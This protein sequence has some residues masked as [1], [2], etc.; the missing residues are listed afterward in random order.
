MNSRKILHSRTTSV[1]AGSALLVTLGGVSG[2]FAAAQ[3]TSQDIKNGEV[4]KVDVGSEAVGASEVLNKSLGTNDLSD[5]AIAAM[6]GQKGDPGG[7]G[8]YTGPEWSVIDRNVLGGGDASLRSGPTVKAFGQDVSPPAGVGSLG[9]RT[10][11]TGDKAAFGD[12]VDFAG[13]KLADVTAVKFSVFT[14]GENGAGNLPNL[15]VEVNP[16]LKKPDGS[17]ITYSTLNFVPASAKANEW[18]EVD[19]STDKRWYFTGTAGAA[20]GCTAA[21]MCSLDEVHTKAPEATIQTVAFSKGSGDAAFSG[22]VDKLVWGDT[23]Y[24]FEPF[25]VRGD[26]LTQR[27]CIREGRARTPGPPLVVRPSSSA[28]F[29][30]ARV[31][32]AETAAVVRAAGH[33]S[34]VVGWLPSAEEGLPS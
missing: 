12:Q 26:Q 29:V 11:G 31:R 28:P 1:I 22:A 5:A 9:I 34:P 3:I 14:T 30:R 17:D 33:P 19:G 25:G 20:S 24:D 7:P 10:G 4:K 8:S 27:R 2:A 32:G 16:H 18:S 23:T 13:D 21:T 15:A 6:K